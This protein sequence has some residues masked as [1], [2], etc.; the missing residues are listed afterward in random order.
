MDLYRDR[1]ITTVNYII[2]T[3]SRQKKYIESVIY[4]ETVFRT[5]VTLTE[6]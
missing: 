2:L 5:Y 1:Y 6:K 4:Y 3:M